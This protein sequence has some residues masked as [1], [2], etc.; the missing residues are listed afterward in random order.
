MWNAG[1]GGCWQGEGMGRS[2]G[3]ERVGVVDWEWGVEFTIGRGEERGGCGGER[4]D[5]GVVRG[6]EVRGWGG[7]EA[8][9]KGGGRGVKMVMRGWGFGCMRTGWEE[10]EPKKGPERLLSISFLQGLEGAKE[11]LDS[12]KRA[13]CT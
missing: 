7:G 12:K 10:E 11:D 2:G 8:R 3:G 6:G 13:T 9:R 1:A 5:K 4:V